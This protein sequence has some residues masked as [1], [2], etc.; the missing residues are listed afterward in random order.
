[1]WCV[2]TLPGRWRGEASG[3]ELNLGTLVPGKKARP[4]VFMR[5]GNGEL[6]FAAIEDPTGRPDFRWFNFVK[7]VRREDIGYRFW[8]RGWSG[9]SWEAT[10]F[11]SFSLIQSAK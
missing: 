5:S 8:D 6:L 1:V 7:R 3:I 2:P 11:A 10:P 9:A 4:A